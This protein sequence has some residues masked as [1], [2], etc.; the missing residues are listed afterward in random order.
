MYIDSFL[1]PNV[2]NLYNLQLLL[3]RV[4]YSEQKKGFV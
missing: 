4:S 1:H 2:L 3:Y